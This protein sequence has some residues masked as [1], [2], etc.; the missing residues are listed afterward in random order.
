MAGRTTQ[1]SN[2]ELSW[3]VD[4]VD[5]FLSHSW[6][7]NGSH[8]WQKLQDWRMRF[9]HEHQQRDRRDEAIA[10]AASQIK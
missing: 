8:K 5:Y 10:R 7:D 9:K 2:Y 4:Q 6:H 3:T 1:G